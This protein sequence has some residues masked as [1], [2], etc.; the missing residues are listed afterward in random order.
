[1]QKLIVRNFGPIR[2]LDL[3]IKDLSLFIGEQATGKSTVA[4]LVY[5]FKSLR[6]ELISS[7][8]DGNAVWG[9]KENV[10]TD[11]LE[12]IGERFR[13]LFGSN[14]SNANNSKSEIKYELAKNVLV[15][16]RPSGGWTI[17]VNLEFG[18]SDTKD[19]WDYIIGQIS[20]FRKDYFSKEEALLSTSEYRKIEFSKKEEINF[21]ETKINNFFGDNKE[22]VFIPASRSFLATFSDQ[23]TNIHSGDFTDDFLK[24]ISSLKP[25]FYQP[26]R[27]IIAERK[28]RGN[29]IATDEELDLAVKKIKSILKG[30]YRKD[31]EG[32][33][34]Y[35]DENNF[36]K[37][38]V[39]SS[40]QQE[41]VWILL[42]LFVF[43]LN[44]DS[45][46]LVIEEPEAHLFPEAQ[47]AMVELIA[48][49]FK[50]NNSQVV[51]T[52]HSPYILTSFNN[53]I[54]AA[55]VGDKYALGASKIV[56]PLLWLYSNRVGAYRLANGTSED[57]MDE[58][59]KMIKA[60]ELDTVSQRINQ[61]FDALLNLELP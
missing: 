41:S 54:Y 16:I 9:K 51:V 40:G 29:H 56:D 7:L 47:K 57:I 24:R 27:Q 52:T 42:L 17:K 31:K 50:S 30:E 36:V 23:I 45:V 59:S 11:F 10:H 15:E 5:F 39:A 58:E 48:L 49:L 55:N 8:Y 32:E 61:D 35:F 46:F 4:K 44:K 53:L 19:K 22:S 37:L 26:L 25:A 12:V 3:D 13:E 60:E 33:K 1:M 18:S 28:Q 21:I 43:I 20:A 2:E 34:I 14:I 38:S 6:R